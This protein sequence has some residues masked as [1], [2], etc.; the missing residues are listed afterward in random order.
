MTLVMSSWNWWYTRD[1]T[2]KY[3]YG[4]KRF[5]WLQDW[6]DS[7]KLYHVRRCGSLHLS[8]G[9]APSGH[10]THR[11]SSSSTR[12]GWAEPDLPIT[13]RSN[14][15]K[16]FKCRKVKMFQIKWRNTSEMFGKCN[17]TKKGQ[18]ERMKRARRSGTEGRDQGRIRIKFP[19]RTR[20]RRRKVWNF[21]FWNICTCMG[22]TSHMTGE[23]GGGGGNFIP[24]NRLESKVFH[25]INH[26]S[27]N[28]S[29]STP[30]SSPHCY[31][32]CYLLL[33]LTR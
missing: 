26:S 23:G 18:E 33:L 19:T 7:V 22:Y 8:Q 4:V 30:L 11:E 25:P 2:T 21:Y 31:I 10:H 16:S 15:G 12:I 1:G 14:E 9:A 27:L 29:F 24:L 5:T 28:D 6:P 20:R 13:S 17:L 32:S 3:V